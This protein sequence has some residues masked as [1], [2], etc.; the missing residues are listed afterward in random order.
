M[1]ISGLQ[2]FWIIFSM[3]MGEGVL[4]TISPTISESQQGAWISVLIAGGFGVLLAL[5]ATKLSLIHPNQTFIEYS[6]TI[7]GKWLG[8]IIL[9]P[10]LIHCY[11]AFAGILRHFSEIVLMVLLPRTDMSLVILYMLLVVIYVTYQGIEGIGR[12]SEFIGLF[13][14]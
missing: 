14:F 13:S 3:Q 7:L 9:V 5:I 8:K 1:V 12:C 11:T 2:I 10:F 4:L 6:Q